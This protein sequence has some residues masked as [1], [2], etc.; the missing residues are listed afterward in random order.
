VYS[1]AFGTV[2][3]AAIIYGIFL[4]GDFISNIIEPHTAIPGSLIGIVLLLSLIV[5][6]L[7]RLT[8]LDHTSN[9]LLKHVIIFAPLFA[10]LIESYRFV[11]EK[12]IK[13]VITLV[14]ACA[15]VMVICGFATDILISCVQRR[16][17]D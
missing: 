3:Q 10:G 2:F 13:N 14:F 12:N 8:L 17:K 1:R 16:R 15:L 7:L 9:F 4:L 11:E 5:S 6:G